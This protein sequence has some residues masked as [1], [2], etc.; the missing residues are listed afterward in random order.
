MDA[1][2]ESFEIGWGEDLQKK[3]VL[4]AEN[5]PEIHLDPAK[6]PT[7]F[8]HLIPLAERFGIGD[9]IIRG[10]VA[11]QASP[12]EIAELREFMS[13]Y[14]EALD[15]WLAGPEAYQNEFSSE[16]IAFSCLREAADF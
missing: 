7:Q 11:R 8:R 3:Y 1:N 10:E 16:Y 13:N 12:L 5:R 2:E 15:E 4:Y 6:V 9:D 14:D